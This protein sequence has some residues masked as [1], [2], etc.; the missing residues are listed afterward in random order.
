MIENV[1]VNIEDVVT[2]ALYDT[3][4]LILSL[5]H[6]DQQ[7]KPLYKYIFSKLKPLSISS[8]RQSFESDAARVWIMLEFG[9]LAIHNL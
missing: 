7:D 4:P 9:E 5:T 6:C 1:A 2:R 8:K 3:R